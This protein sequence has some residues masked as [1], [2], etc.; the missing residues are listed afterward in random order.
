MKTSVAVF[1]ENIFFLLRYVDAAVQEA[2]Y[3]GTNNLNEFSAD[4]ENALNKGVQDIET[5]V[6]GSL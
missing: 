2:T 4:Y 3:L 6:D 1:N 5:P